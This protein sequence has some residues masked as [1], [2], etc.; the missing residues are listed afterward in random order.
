MISSEDPIY[1][2]GV[3]EVHLTENEVATT[4]SKKAPA[5]PAILN[6]WNRSLEEQTIDQIDS[7]QIVGKKICKNTVSF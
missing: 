2:L 5:S 6:E 1:Y 4:S 7:A 3:V